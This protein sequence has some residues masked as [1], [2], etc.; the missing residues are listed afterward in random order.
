MRPPQHPCLTRPLS[1]S[2]ASP[3]HAGTT[4]YAQEYRA[5][6]LPEKAV[7]AGGPYAPPSVPFDGT[8]TYKN[9]FV[10]HELEA[11][12]P[13]APHAPREVLPFEGGTTYGETFRPYPILPRE[14]RAP[15]AMAA[16][17][18]KFEGT[19][20]TMDA[21]RAWAVDPSNRRG[22]PPPPMR[23][24]I[25]F[26]GTTTNAEM[27]K[28]W[29]LPPRRP[30]LGLQMAGD[31]AYVLVPANAPVPAMGRQVFTTVHDNQTDISLLV[32]EG[33]FKEASRCN[34]IGQFDMAGLPPGPAGSCK[35]EVCLHI[36]Q[37]GVMTCTA[38]DLNSQRQ[39]QWLRQGH[40]YAHPR[41]AAAAA[42]VAARTPHGLV[43]VELVVT[44]AAYRHMYGMV[45]DAAGCCMAATAALM[46]QACTSVVCTA[47]CAAN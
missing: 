17:G 6:P 29:Q 38:V 46:H 20:T 35:I 36:D 14:R 26:E 3:R 39:E 10:Q 11:R 12:A 42:A 25:P 1:L 5:H 44:P 43:C 8:S 28:G 40:M 45:V 27:F 13:R 37:E 47:V 41:G 31:R 9:Q 4:S 30:A 15:P 32:I 24:A 16:T 23:P 34:V 22:G 2:L 33:D 21:Y 7:F 19:T 18:A